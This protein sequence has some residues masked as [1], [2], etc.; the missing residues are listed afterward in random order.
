MV[1]EPHQGGAQQM[2]RG[3]KSAGVVLADVGGTNVRFAVLADAVLGRV[4][5][6][7]VADYLHFAD[8]LADFMS[9]R[10]EAG[11]I[12]RAIFAVAGVVDGKRCAL[13]NNPWIVDS[14]EL[15]AR[16]ALSD[17]LIVNDFEAIAWSLPRL[18]PED[19]Q[20]LGGLK[21]KTGAPMLAI[22]P[23]T[24]L[25]VAVYAASGQ[26]G[27]V[28]RSE[29]GHATMPAASAR[30]DAIIEILRRRF[31]HVSAERVLSGHGLE[32][33]YRA[34]ASLDSLDV[35]ERS[36]AE[37]TR[38]GLEGQCAASRAAIDMFCAMLGET[39]GNLALGAGAQ[40]GVYIAG[41]IAAHLRDY[42]PW[43]QFRARFEGKGRMSSYVSA[44]PAFLILHKDPAFLGLQSLA[45]RTA[46]VP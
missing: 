33:L 9:R 2:T 13:T 11:P 40:G 45:A 1:P 42:L 34:I 3:E 41:G 17:V 22:G 43:S 38:F 20:K 6:R 36:A 12:R 16:F 14:D 28:L 25:G 23:G 24:G 8:A 19:L 46:W 5:R 18:T 39:A 27:F 15:R 4:E 44:I 26:G 21:A 29:G 30:E 31:G 10:T 37:I 7:A 32:N 35:P